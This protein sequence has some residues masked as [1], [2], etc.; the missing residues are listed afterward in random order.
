MSEK[1]ELPK[2]WLKEVLEEA[3]ILVEQLPDWLQEK[4]N[5]R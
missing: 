5:D 4:T 3:K 2:G 1:V